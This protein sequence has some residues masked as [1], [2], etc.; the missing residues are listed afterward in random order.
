MKVVDAKA[1]AYMRAKAGL[2]LIRFGLCL[3]LATGPTWAGSFEE[4]TA[5]YDQH[6][7]A[8]AMKLWLPLAEQGHR[9]AQFNL[10]VLYERGF[11]VPQDATQA[12]RWYL[13]AAKQGDVQAQ[14]NVGVFYE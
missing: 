14:Y 3:L 8:T 1:A 9:A 5:A 10:G 2:L 4:G 11:G 7:Y 6:D 12:A 13:E